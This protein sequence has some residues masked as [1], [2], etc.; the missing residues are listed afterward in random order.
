MDFTIDNKDKYR[1]SELL[2]DN[3]KIFILCRMN[4]LLD[5]MLLDSSFTDLFRVKT[6]LKN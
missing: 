4:K 2:E 6:V 1:F 3:L 5:C